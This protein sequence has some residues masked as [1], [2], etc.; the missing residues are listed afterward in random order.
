MRIRTTAER[1]RYLRRNIGLHAR[2][3][4]ELL[5]RGVSKDLRAGS[6]G[7][8]IANRGSAR[9]RQAGTVVAQ[10]RVVLQRSFEPRG[11]RAPAREE[12]LPLTRRR[13]RF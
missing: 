10:R 2:V 5:R 9:G 7:P 6:P 11:R 1:G 13:G 8:I 3:S 12:L 4:P